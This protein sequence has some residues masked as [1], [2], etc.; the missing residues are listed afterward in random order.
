VPGG[1]T[2]TANLQP[3]IVTSHLGTAIVILLR[4]CMTTISDYLVDQSRTDESSK[5]RSLAKGT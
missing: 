3:L 5:K 4:L 2:V 1:L